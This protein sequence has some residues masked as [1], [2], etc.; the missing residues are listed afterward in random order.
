[1]IYLSIPTLN[2]PALALIYH[3]T[4]DSIADAQ[5]ARD[6]L[7]AVFDPSPPAVLGGCLSYE[8]EGLLRFSL[9]RDFSPVSLLHSHKTPVPK[10]ARFWILSKNRIFV[11]VW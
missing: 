7:V 10:K 5:N 4:L 8:P 3:S 2:P 9:H 1:M 11:L 6:L